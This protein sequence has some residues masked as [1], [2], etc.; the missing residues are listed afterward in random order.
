[1][2]ILQ[3]N[4]GKD[5]KERSGLR[6]RST[7]STPTSS[8]HSRTDRV[9]SFCFTQFRVVQGVKP[10][11]LRADIP[12]CRAINHR[13]LHAKHLFEQADPAMVEQRRPTRRAAGVGCAFWR[14]SR[15]L[16][17]RH[18]WAAGVHVA[19]SDCLSV[20]LLRSSR[21]STKILRNTLPH[22]FVSPVL[23]GRPAPECGLSAVDLD[24]RRAAA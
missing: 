1:F 21:L 22:R 11:Y 16:S 23:G 18:G 10:M 19:E 24:G 9:D 5:I 17:A 2:A 14:T 15:I 8:E 12:R 4:S 6:Q 3:C 7:T 20:P 13:M